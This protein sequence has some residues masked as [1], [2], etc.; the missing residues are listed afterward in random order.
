MMTKIIIESIERKY[1]IGRPI[2]ATIW[3]VQLGMNLIQDEVMMLEEI[4]FFIFKK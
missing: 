2:V 3:D 4:S 1:A